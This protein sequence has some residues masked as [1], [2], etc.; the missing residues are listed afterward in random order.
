MGV[1]DRINNRLE[2]KT[3]PC[4]FKT[5]VAPQ[6]VHANAPKTS[7]YM[8][9]TSLRHR[10]VQGAV[11]EERESRGTRVVLGAVGGGRVSECAGTT[12]VNFPTS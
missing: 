12:T 4:T 6:G 7:A 5:K 2:M 3:I 9:Q 10:H 8:S 1:V 11:H